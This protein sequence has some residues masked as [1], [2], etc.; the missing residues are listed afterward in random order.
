MF[1]NLRSAAM[2]ITI[3]A[4]AAICAAAEKPATVSGI[5][6]DE[7]GKPLSRVSWWISAFEEWRD[8]EWQIVHYTGDTRE[9][10]TD[11][12]GRFEVEFH[13]KLRYD[14][15]FDK[16][17]YAP[18]FL[19][20]VSPYDPFT[21]LLQR[22]SGGQ[23]GTDS[24]HLHVTMKKGVLVRGEV[25]IVGK[26][27][28]DFEGI[29]VALR[30]PNSRG[31]WFKRTTLVDHEGKFRFYAGPPLVGPGPVSKWQLVC[32]GEIV[33]LDVREDKPVDEVIFQINATSRR[34]SSTQKAQ[35]SQ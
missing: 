18:A 29:T 5:V 30:L 10:T 1:S 25:E 13:R 33:M 2:I 11:E 16:W 7:S 26:N 14:L 9:H 17:G 34:K 6:T 3:L 22:R 32:A 28:P 19:F 12:T 27:R 15:Q 20:Q 35:A 4:F 31:L 21:L 8:G 24:R 23:T